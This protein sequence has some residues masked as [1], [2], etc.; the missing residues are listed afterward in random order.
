VHCKRLKSGL[1][2]NDIEFIDVD[3]HLKE[4]KSEVEEVFKMTGDEMIPIIMVKPHILAPN[5]SF[6]T[7]EDA[8]K[9]IIN[10]IKK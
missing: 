10:L 9:L 5:K 8:I 3:V 7:I 6:K 2:N 1:T 4:N